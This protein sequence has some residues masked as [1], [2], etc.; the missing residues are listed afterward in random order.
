MATAKKQDTAQAEAREVMQEP[1]GGWPAD[2]FTGMAGTF[3]RDPYTGK[4]HPEGQTSGE[5]EQPTAD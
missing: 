2:E 3:I 5:Q 4:R 1:A